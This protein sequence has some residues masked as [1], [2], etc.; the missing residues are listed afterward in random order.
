M[1]KVH[2][3]TAY[4]NIIKKYFQHNNLHL[5]GASSAAKNRNILKKTHS[6]NCGSLALIVIKYMQ[7]VN[8]CIG[9]VVR[10]LV[11]P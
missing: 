5:I 11:L 7:A 10:T 8:L 4:C 2:T 6:K 1:F 3:R 9:I